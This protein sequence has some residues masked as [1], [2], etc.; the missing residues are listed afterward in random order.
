MIDWDDEPRCGTCIFLGRPYAKN[1]YECRR[2]PPGQRSEEG[3][4]LNELCGEGRFLFDDLTDAPA[5]QFGIPFII[6]LQEFHE[7]CERLRYLDFQI[8]PE[9]AVSPEEP[10]GDSGLSTQDEGGR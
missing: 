4:E 2:Y 7:L 6:S 8:A 1:V 5:A 9:D 10:D 3:V